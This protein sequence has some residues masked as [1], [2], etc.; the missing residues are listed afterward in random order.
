MFEAH[1][2][3]TPVTHIQDLSMGPASSIAELQ[4]D[5]QLLLLSTNMTALSAVCIVVR[6][7]T[8]LLPNMRSICFR[9]NGQCA[10]TSPQLKLATCNMPCAQRRCKSATQNICVVKQVILSAESV[11][12]LERL[13]ATWLGMCIA[14]GF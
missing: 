5:Q 6:L 11:T 4:Y 13:L 14:C 10:W 2:R 12:D 7:Q 9:C 1:L 8:A 3:G